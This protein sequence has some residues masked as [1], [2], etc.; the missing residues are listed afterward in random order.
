M[1]V[2]Q[3]VCI[4]DERVAAQVFGRA[5]V[6]VLVQI[7][8]RAVKLQHIVGELGHQCTVRGTLQR[9]DDVRLAALLAHQSWQRLQVNRLAA[10]VQREASQLRRQN[11]VR[12][13][14]WLGLACS[15]SSSRPTKVLSKVGAST[16]LAERCP[17]ELTCIP[18]RVAKRSYMQVKFVLMSLR[19]FTDELGVTH[20]V[21]ASKANNSW[22]ATR[23]IRFPGSERSNRPLCELARTSERRIAATRIAWHA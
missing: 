13:V 22:A 6:R 20:N 4:A 1:A 16:K 2:Q 7:V 21:L 5:D 19:Y 15:Q 18:S 12:T 17:H 9:D 3:I 14:G 11:Q 10:V 8:T 23:T